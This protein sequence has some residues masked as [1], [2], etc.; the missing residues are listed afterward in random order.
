[1]AVR[2]RR[3]AE[4]VMIGVASARAMS[5]L[6]RKVIEQIRQTQQTQSVMTNNEMQAIRTLVRLSLMAPS[7]LFDWFR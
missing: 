7:G 3:G 1:M 2:V 6:N 4:R 5:L